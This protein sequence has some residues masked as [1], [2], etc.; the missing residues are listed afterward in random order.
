MKSS[1]RLDICSAI[2][3]PQKVAR[4]RRHRGRNMSTM[5]YT[6]LETLRRVH[7]GWRLLAAD[8]APLIV[9]FLHAHFIRP[10]VRTASQQDLV[11]KLDDHLF[12]LREQLGD[13]AFP[14]SAQAYLDD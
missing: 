7:P 9:S 14:R 13:A 5:D 2:K 4:D 8:H 11:S 6:S 12:H 3:E 1:L 10:N